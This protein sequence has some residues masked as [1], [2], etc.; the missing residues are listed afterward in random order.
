MILASS[1][2]RRKTLLEFLTSDF[3]V[4]APDVDETI[5]EPFA[6]GLKAV[7]ERKRDAVPGRVVLA[8]DTIGISDTILLKPK[9]EAQARKM[10]EHL[11]GNSHEV[12]TAVAVTGQ[13]T[14]VVTTRVEMN[15]PAAVLKEYLAS[16]EW[17]GKAG[18]YGIQDP[19][20]APYLKISGPWS[21][22]AGLPIRATY[23]MLLAAGVDVKMPPT[24][25]ELADQNPFQ[26]N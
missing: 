15:I 2:P 13:P 21:N 9:N 24:E 6:A 22:V 7:A 26:L 3:T 18:A 23:Q 12:L 17:K 25:R 10:L 19:L 8:A 11:N 4:E 5:T 14:L 16:G 20:I 1:S